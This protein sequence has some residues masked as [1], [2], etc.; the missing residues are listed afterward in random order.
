MEKIQ[1]HDKVISYNK[2][3]VNH[4]SQ[5]N[6]KKDIE[7]EVLILSLKIDNYDFRIKYSDDELD[8]FRCWNNYVLCDILFSIFHNI[9]FS[10]VIGSTLVNYLLGYPIG[11]DRDID[12]VLSETSIRVKTVIFESHRVV[13]TQYI[14]DLESQDIT[15][16]IKSELNVDKYNLLHRESPDSIKSLYLSKRLLDKDD[17]FKFLNNYDN[18]DTKINLDIITLS[19]KSNNIRYWTRMVPIFGSKAI[20]TFITEIHRRTHILSI[21][22]DYIVKDKKRVI[23]FNLNNFL[24]IIKGLRIFNIEGITRENGEY[25]PIRSKDRFKETDEFK[26]LKDYLRYEKRSIPNNQIRNFFKIGD[27]VII[28]CKNTL[29]FW[30]YGELLTKKVPKDF[31]YIFGKDAKRIHSKH[32][33]IKIKSVLDDTIDDQ[34]NICQERYKL[35]SPIIF[36]KCKTDNHKYHLKCYINM[37]MKYIEGKIS[38]F[39]KDKMKEI[40][41][42]NMNACPICRSDLMK[43]DW[44]SN[45]KTLRIKKGTSKLEKCHITEKVYDIYGKDELIL[46]SGKTKELCNLLI[47]N[48]EHLTEYP[49][50]EDYLVYKWGLIERLHAFETISHDIK[51]DHLNEI[52]DNII[53]THI[54]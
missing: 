38:I 6:T 41:S 32:N 4:N 43:I 25:L 20:F 53:G 28:E 36:T 54:R 30:I 8:L 2:N 10:Y 52:Y 18:G 44:Y 39:N 29:A 50:L 31:E 24:L 45:N 3:R 37:V 34:C 33:E 7:N 14:S 22:Y 26:D 13:D 27:P 16:I 5:R 51:S 23:E 1:V 42:T 49:T 17:K 11:G 15:S 12:I 21:L 9:D 46:V 35:S 40:L 48:I 19:D 47:D